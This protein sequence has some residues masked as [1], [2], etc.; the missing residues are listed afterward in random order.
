MRAR[1]AEFA[2][3][4]TEGIWHSNERFFR[5]GGRGEWRDLFTEGV[6]R[7]YHDRINQL[8]PPDL[9]AWAHEGRRFTL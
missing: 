2:P 3:D 9:L 4:A 6:N 8:A 7:R 5:A 1:A